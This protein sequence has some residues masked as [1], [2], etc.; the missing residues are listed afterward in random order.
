MKQQLRTLCVLSFALPLHAAVNQNSVTE[1]LNLGISARAAGMGHAFSAVGG[2]LTSL[3]SNP[4]GLLFLPIPQAGTQYTKAKEEKAGGT[5]GYAVPLVWGSLAVSGL[6]R[7]GRDFVVSAAMARPLLGRARLNALG[8]SL[9]TIH[10]RLEG[11]NASTSAMDIGTLWKIPSQNVTVAAGIQNMGKPVKFQTETQ[12]LPQT[13][14]AGVAWHIPDSTGLGYPQTIAADFFWPKEGSYHYSV[15]GEF[16]LK[17]ETFLRAGYEFKQ[18]DAGLALGIGWKRTS[19]RLDYAV[20]FR[21]ISEK[22]HRV[23]LLWFIAPPPPPPPKRKIG[24][25]EV[26]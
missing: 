1:L 2:D 4:A 13:V 15:G 17:T 26:K 21:D 9:K 23:S 18:E 20:S 12:L 22:I 7:E 14:R 6:K 25:M 16:T 24:G 3:E 8:V 19:W 5:V 10:S 11:D